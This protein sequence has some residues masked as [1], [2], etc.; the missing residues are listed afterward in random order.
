MPS[1]FREFDKLSLVRSYSKSG[2]SSGSKR[3]ARKQR[4]N[5]TNNKLMYIFTTVNR[6]SPYYAKDK[7]LLEKV[8][9]RFKNVHMNQTRYDRRV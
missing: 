2:R 6:F 3:C 7:E 9:Q 5:T 4:A 1:F 8:A